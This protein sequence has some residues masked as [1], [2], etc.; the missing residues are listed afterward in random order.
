VNLQAAKLVDRWLGAVA[1]RVLRPWRIARDLLG[2]P[3]E[4]QSVREVAA[5]KFWGVGNAALLLPL[6]DKL[7]R[8]YPA[9]RLTVVTFESNRAVLEGAADRLLAVR[10]EHI[11]AD[12]FRALA[13]LRKDRIDIA[14]DFEQYARASQIL[15]FLSGAR[16]VIAFD[17]PGQHRAHLADVRVPYDDGRHAAEGFLELARAAGVADRRYRAGG[18]APT[19]ATAERVEAWVAR[20][21]IGDRPLVVLHPGSGDNFPGRRWPTRRFGLVARR[22]VDECGAAVAV[23]GL[24]RE[25]RLAREVI[26]ASERDL[27]HLAGALSLE[28]L[29]AL[30]ARA[31]LLVSND[32]GPVHLASALSVPVVGLYGPNTPRLYG[33]LS[34]LSTAFYD[35]PACSPCITNLNYKT[36]RCRNPVCIRAIDWEAVGNAAVSVLQVRRRAGRRA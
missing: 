19:P 2:D 26:E 4:L 1:L 20:H 5:V 29:I 35:A 34:A 33:P 23:T 22:L 17:M 14:V 9:A 6:L 13:V 12:F 25:R 16:Q 27:F 31:Q 15:L 18:L 11:V 28:E 24:R 8:R 10:P 30:I 7:K 32:T 36:S 3:R 21:D